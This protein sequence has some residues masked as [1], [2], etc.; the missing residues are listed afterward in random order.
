ML[1]A[2]PAAKQRGAPERYRGM[3]GEPTR[4][5][6]DE[7][8]QLGA[9]VESVRGDAALIAAYR[10]HHEMIF[11]FLRRATRD[12]ATAEDLLQETFARLLTEYRA[13]RSPEVLLPWLYRVASN[14]VISRG[15]R[16]RSALRWLTVE[17]ARTGAI[18][19]V[20]S[21]ELSVLRR[22]RTDD[23]DRTLRVLQADARVAL[24][25]SAD[26][27]SGREIAAA[28][29]RSEAAT[30]VL[31]CRARRRMRAEL[32]PVEVVR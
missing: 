12:D 11:A 9:P 26:G 23:L 10:D 21:P 27:F 14:L 5:Q 24:L 25:L 2:A 8:A 15:R 16:L 1:Q 18:D 3:D 30:R 20:E 17:R 28:I 6:R 22:E 19:G 29:G 32:E 13:G 31:L 4:L 7:A